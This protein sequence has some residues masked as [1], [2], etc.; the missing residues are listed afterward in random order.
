VQ[1]A[2]SP[3][4]ENFPGIHI[5]QVFTPST[6]L[7]EKPGSQVVSRIHADDPF[8]VVMKP[9]GQSKQPLW[10]KFGAYVFRGQAEQPL[11]SKLAEKEPGGHK[12]QWSLSPATVDAFTKK[13]GLHDES[14]VVLITFT[15]PAQGVHEADCTTGLYVPAGH[16]MQVALKPPVLYVP[17]LHG[18]QTN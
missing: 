12:R 17:L 14:Q 9:K 6:T 3:P 4:A 13:P 16:S 15:L 7:P 8:A 10:P 5:V 2:L 18:E 1:L 11:A